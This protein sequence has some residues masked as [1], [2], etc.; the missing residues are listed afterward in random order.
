[1]DP[2]TDDM[3]YRLLL[4]IHEIKAPT[5]RQRFEKLLRAVQTDDEGPAAEPVAVDPSKVSKVE[6][7]L[8][9]TAAADESDTS[10]GF[11]P[12]SSTPIKD[13]VPFLDEVTSEMASEVETDVNAQRTPLKVTHQ[14]RTDGFQPI[15]WDEDSLHTLGYTLSKSLIESDSL[16]DE[17]A[18]GGG[19]GTVVGRTVPAAYG[20]PVR[21][22]RNSSSASSLHAA[23][24]LPVATPPIRALST[25]K[26]M[27][28][29]ENEAYALE[30]HCAYD[31]AAMLEQAVEFC[32]FGLKSRM[33]RNWLAVFEAQTAR[34]ADNA[35]QLEHAKK[36]RLFSR[37][38]HLRDR[39]QRSGSYA[40]RIHTENVQHASWTR[41]R[42]ALCYRRQDR[43]ADEL[44]ERRVAR[45]TRTAFDSWLGRV[46]NKA[47]EK[48]MMEM[49]R[50]EADLKA[51]RER[52]L[53]QQA[54]NTWHDARS[55]HAA[56]A[57]HEAGLMLSAFATWRFN[58]SHRSDLRNKEGSLAVSDASR[59]L[60][61]SFGEWRRRRD[62]REREEVQRQKVEKEIAEEA[63][64][65]WRGAL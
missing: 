4:K 33:F 38:T 57:Y 50:K 5:L 36:C 23:S 53:L 10:I 6:R 65:R 11:R 54:F 41:W 20:G 19:G 17:S 42:Q 52:T 64:Q 30:E 55:M 26:A 1:M 3:Y 56:I 43:L 25:S 18:E 28:Q 46:R 61:R 62:L 27:L 13:K 31:T 14:Q 58:A 49:G 12:S 29:L 8:A 35:A 40:E 63:W 21:R 60:R 7:W 39:R 37:W 45:Q 2:S 34:A 51:R 22:R 32:S 9:T 48:W 16:A 59:L 15:R 44:L 24:D 47:K